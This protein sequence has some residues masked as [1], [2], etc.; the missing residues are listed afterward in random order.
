MEQTL[1]KT[2]IAMGSQWGGDQRVLRSSNLTSPYSDLSTIYISCKV[3]TKP[4]GLMHT[5]ESYQSDFLTILIA[6]G[7]NR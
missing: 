2:K 7:T 5:C 4:T 1:I 6:S 3:R